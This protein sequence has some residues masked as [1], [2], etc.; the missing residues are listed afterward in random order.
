M[1]TPIHR[2]PVAAWQYLCDFGGIELDGRDEGLDKRIH[3]RLDP[4]L[5]CLEDA[6]AAA[7]MEAFAQAFFHSI[8]PYVEMFRNIL[9]FFEHSEATQG[10]SQWTLQVDEID[11][12]L[13]HFR[14]WLA[15]CDALAK[16]EIQVPAIDSK[17]VWELLRTLGQPIGDELRNSFSKGSLNVAND[18]RAW[19]SA[20]N[21][22]KYLPLP[23]SL[24]PPACPEELWK[25]ASIALAALQRLLDLG[26]T[27]SSLND[28]YDNSIPLDPSDALDFRTIAQ[29][30]TDLW[31]RSFVV[32]LSSA[33]TLLSDSELAAVGAE[34]EEFT[35]KFPMRPLQVDVAISDLESIL[36]LPIWKKRYDLYS[37]WIATE[38]IRSLDGHDIEIHHDNGRIAFAFKETLVATIHSPPGP[39][40][41]ISERRI[42]LENPQG[43]GRKEGVQPD[44]GL[45]MVTHGAEVC[46]MAIE[47]KHYKNSAKAKFLDVFEDYARALP[48]SDVYLVN[49]GPAGNA[50]YEV[51]RC[52]R[53]R[54]NA[55]GHLTPSN[56][57]TREQ[58][59]GAVRE[60]VGE[61]LISWPSE[62]ATTKGTK[63]LLFDVSG[64]MK[65]TMRSDAMN[66]FVRSLASTELPAKLVA[67][68]S[69]IVGTWNVNESGFAELLRV[70][71]GSTE[72]RGPIV[73]LLDSYESVLVVTDDG[74][75]TTIRDVSVAPH[76]SQA[77]APAGTNVR[78]CTIA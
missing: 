66:A 11:I 4:S 34:L 54:C 53:D 27:P 46:K 5:P 49:H 25:S 41:L 6:L 38:V 61:P 1:S 55:I 28:I 2:D 21:S 60:C 32:A 76:D 75:L 42:P 63:V 69:T 30:E 3:N 58:L 17:A 39:F 65:R 64:S 48:H 13:E 33:G 22:D 10:E 67:A 8:H 20:Y 40:R 19:V 47:V 36:S 62:S 68:D 23:E 44:H 78:V 35:D 57:Q 77:A 14:T 12:D 29:N 16:M 59:A 56:N 70:D 72:L 43:E 18:V 50:V 73:E 71:G 26:M 24:V 74:G 52:V 51:S 9:D 37:V 7:S 31:L 45:W 15:A